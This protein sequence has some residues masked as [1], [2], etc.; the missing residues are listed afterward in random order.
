MREALRHVQRTAVL[1]VQLNGNVVEIARAFRAQIYDDIKN[2]AAGAPH[3]LGLRRRRKLEV[4]STHCALPKVVRDICLCDNGLESVSGEFFLA[5]SSRE[6]PSW[7]FPAF[8]VDNVRSLK[9][10]FSEFHEEC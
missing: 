10:C 3:Q 1:F 2:R 9:L 8:K 6:K 5:E 7:V 4:H